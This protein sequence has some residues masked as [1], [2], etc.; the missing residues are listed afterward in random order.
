[1]TVAIVSM[2]QKSLTRIELTM[3]MISSSDELEPEP[4][5]PNLKVSFRIIVSASIK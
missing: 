2:G 1:V 4:I 3:Y 5:N